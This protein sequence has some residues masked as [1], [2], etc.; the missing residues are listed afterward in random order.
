M[1][2]KEEEQASLKASLGLFDV[3]KTFIDKVD[4]FVITSL[5]PFNVRL[6]AYLK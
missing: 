2:S 4:S 5:S 6:L 1:G 3:Q